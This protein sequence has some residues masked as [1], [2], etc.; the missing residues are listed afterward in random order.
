VSNTG[1]NSNNGQTGK[2]R[3]D[4]LIGQEGK[5]PFLSRPTPTVVGQDTYAQKILPST[6]PASFGA[7]ANPQIATN[8]P[9]GGVAAAPKPPVAAANPIQSPSYASKASAILRPFA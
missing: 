5:N 6:M 4:T 8:S 1:Q 3:L 9:F 7:I 2:T